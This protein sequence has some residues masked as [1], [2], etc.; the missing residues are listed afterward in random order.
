MCRFVGVVTSAETNRGWLAGGTDTAVYQHCRTGLRISLFLS[1][2]DRE[3][4]NF[5]ERRIGGGKGTG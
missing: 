2:V 4:R 5:Q 1:Q 3:G